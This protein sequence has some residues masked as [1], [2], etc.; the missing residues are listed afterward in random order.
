VQNLCFLIDRRLILLHSHTLV[1]LGT[2][3]F[4]VCKYV[5]V[6]GVRLY[7]S[8]RKVRQKMTGF[9]KVS[10]RLSPF[11]GV[12]GWCGSGASIDTE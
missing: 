3:Q 1:A 5:V 12:V 2:L 9:R 8:M 4:T 11:T 6:A 7:C 10:D